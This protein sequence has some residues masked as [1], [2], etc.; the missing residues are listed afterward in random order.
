MQEKAQFGAVRASIDCES[1]LTPVDTMPSLGQ[2]RS[3]LSGA[4]VASR[5]EG[6]GD[7][8]TE[9]EFD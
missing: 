9:C 7:H 5:G 6:E 4:K 8:G 2:L 1:T 3:A